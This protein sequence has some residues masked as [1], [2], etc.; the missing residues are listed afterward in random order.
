MEFNEKYNI[1][2]G[3]K[4]I[5]IT[6]S[7]TCKL[8]D[9]NKKTACIMIKEDIAKGKLSDTYAWNNFNSCIS[10]KVLSMKYNQLS[11][12]AQTLWHT[13]NELQPVV[14]MSITEM[15]RESANDQQ[16]SETRRRAY[17]EVYEFAK[18]DSV[19]PS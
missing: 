13:L 18:Q 10:W 12:L 3:D 5:E 14:H 19:I 8:S 11:A 15:A 9:A 1:E 6:H 2:I 4:I 16:L 7:G 17:W